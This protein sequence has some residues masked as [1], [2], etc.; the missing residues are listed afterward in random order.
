[1]FAEKTVAKALIFQ[2]D[3]TSGGIYVAERP[4]FLLLRGVTCLQGLHGA[5]E[6]RMNYG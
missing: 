5:V 3:K 2:S 4:Q 1:M 6:I